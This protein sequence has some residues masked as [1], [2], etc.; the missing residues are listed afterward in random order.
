MPPN[1]RP[2]TLHVDVNDALQDAMSEMLDKQAD[3]DG[4]AKM[5]HNAE[6]W[7]DVKHSE[8]KKRDRI[9]DD[10]ILLGLMTKSDAKGFE[11]LF[12]NLSIMGLAAYGIHRLGV[13]SAIESGNWKSLSTEQWAMFIP[14]YFFFGFCYQ[15]FACKCNHAL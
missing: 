13:F 4:L 8:R 5:N 1:A 7:T 15:S 11:R 12:I 10:G 14:L 6:D 2:T 3:T 9:L